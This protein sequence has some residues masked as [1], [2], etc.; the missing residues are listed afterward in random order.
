MP[1]CKVL[2]AGLEL[3]MMKLQGFSRRRTKMMQQSPARA[4]A[5]AWRWGRG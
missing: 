5:R 3:L 4:S 2:Q 1:C